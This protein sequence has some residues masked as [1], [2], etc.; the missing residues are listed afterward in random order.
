[1]PIFL[2]IG[3]CCG[4]GSGGYIIKVDGTA[5]EDGGKFADKESITFNANASPDAP[6]APPALPSSTCTQCTNN[7]NNWMIKKERHVRL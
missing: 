2:F 5:V 7:T 4:Y 6:T 3:I 1:M